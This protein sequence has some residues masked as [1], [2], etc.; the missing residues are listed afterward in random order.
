M[1]ILFLAGK[2]KQKDGRN[3]RL[4]FAERDFIRLLSKRGMD[5]YQIQTFVSMVFNRH[6]SKE[7]IRFAVAE[8]ESDFGN[9]LTLE[10]KEL[11]HRENIALLEEGAKQYNEKRKERIQQIGLIE[12]ELRLKLKE[13]LE[14]D[15]LPPQVLLKAYEAFFS[16]TRLLANE[17]TSIQRYEKYTDEELQ[18]RFRE[19]TKDKTRTVLYFAGTGEKEE[20]GEDKVLEAAPKTVGGDKIPSQ[21]EARTGGE[22]VG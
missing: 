2:E 22:Q 9:K 11:I 20:G 14:E 12:N 16:Q 19:L 1:A 10:D 15:K 7:Q 3:P 8:L 4:N 5:E 17:P 13:K 18:R 6:L 21:E